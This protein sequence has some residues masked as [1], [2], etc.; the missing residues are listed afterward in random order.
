MTERE[1]IIEWAYNAG[2]DIGVAALG[3]FE[4]CNDEYKSASLSDTLN[5]Y[6]A[7]TELRQQLATAQAD[8]EQLVKALE[9]VETRYFAFRFLKR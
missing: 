6:A 3:Y 2:F 1:K 7:N 8:N 4:G 5:L 9:E